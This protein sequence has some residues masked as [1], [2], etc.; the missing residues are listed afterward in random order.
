[1]SLKER[2]Q[3]YVNKGWVMHVADT[4]LLWVCPTNQHLFIKVAV[5]EVPLTFIAQERGNTYEKTI[6]T[7]NRDYWKQE[8]DDYY[9]GNRYHY[10]R[11]TKAKYQTRARG[12]HS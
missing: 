6:D 12:R 3:V 5:S 4:Y 9:Y 2:I 8:K 1:M 10:E 11:N 7:E